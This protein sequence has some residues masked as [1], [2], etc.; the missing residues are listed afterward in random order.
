MDPH[1]LVQSWAQPCLI[2]KGPGTCRSIMGPSLWPGIWV[3]PQK[4]TRQGTLII[5]LRW[6]NLDSSSWPV[7]GL[8]LHLAPFCLWRL[9][10]VQTAPLRIFPQVLGHSNTF[11]MMRQQ[12]LRH[13]RGTT[14]Q[15]AIWKSLLWSFRHIKPGGDT[16]V[17]PGHVWQMTF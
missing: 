13:P 14:H 9:N 17:D 12:S 10:W 7:L 3:G 15:Y 5:N 8:A 4:P 16:N 6:L 2:G 11:S 1:V